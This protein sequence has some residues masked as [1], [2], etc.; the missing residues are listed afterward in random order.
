[1][2]RFQR[3]FPAH[4]A[5]VCAVLQAARTAGITFR[6]EKYRNIVPNPVFQDMISGTAVSPIEEE[7]FKALSHFPKTTNVSELRS[8]MELVEQFSGFSTEVEAAQCPH[9]PL[10]STRN[11][12]VWT[13]DHNQAFEAV[14]LALIPHQCWSILTRCNRRPSRSMHRANM[15]W[16]MRF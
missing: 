12:F 3:T 4:V 9:R 7:T 6:K 10:L 5:G 16:G 14:K 8:F 2:L 15:V 1:L 13:T 11:P